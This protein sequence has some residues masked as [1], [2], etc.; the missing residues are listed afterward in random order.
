[1]GDGSGPPNKWFSHAGPLTDA[2]ILTLLNTEV[3]D[4]PVTAAFVNPA[5]GTLFVGYYSEED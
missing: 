2:E 5:T 4:T 3:D 1:M